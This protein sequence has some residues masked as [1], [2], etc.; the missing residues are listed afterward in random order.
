MPLACSGHISAHYIFS[1]AE[2][3]INNGYTYSEALKVGLEPDL[4]E[5]SR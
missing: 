1:F 2:D 5:H 4:R 3:I